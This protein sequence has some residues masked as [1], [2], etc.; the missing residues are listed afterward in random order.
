MTRRIMIDIETMSTDNCNALI[1]SVGAVE[2]AMD[3]TGVLVLASKLWVLNPFEQLA[4]G[5]GTT[6]NTLAWWKQ[7][8]PAARAHWLGGAPV[9][10]AQFVSELHS[11]FAVG[12]EVW[13]NGIVFDLG[14]LSALFEQ[15]GWKLPWAYN[16]AMDARTLYLTTPQLR[17]RPADL[18]NGPAHDPVADCKNQAWG[19]W[20]HWPVGDDLVPA[21]PESEL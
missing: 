18:D 2:W 9:K 19:V 1:L 16:K 15:A 17:T 10:V 3:T 7:Q 6:P 14:N 20:E 5:R 13:A 4:L 12:T 21:A 11:M 8:I